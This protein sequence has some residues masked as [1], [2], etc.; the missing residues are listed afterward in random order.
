LKLPASEVV[1]VG[2]SYGHDVLAARR[3]GLRAI[4]VDALDLYLDVEP[5]RI[6]RLGELVNV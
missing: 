4:L 3:A 1:Y 6:K 5:A 2:D